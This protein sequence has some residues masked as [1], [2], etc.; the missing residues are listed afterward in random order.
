M[1]TLK[2]LPP[3]IRSAHLRE[4]LPGQSLPRADPVQDRRQLHGLHGVR[5]QLPGGS[6][7]R[8]SAGRARDRS[9]HVHQVRHLHAGVQL[10]RGDGCCT[11][12]H[13]RRA[14][15]LRSHESG[16]EAFACSASEEAV[17]DRDKNGKDV[18]QVV[19]AA[20]AQHGAT[21]D[22]SIPILTDVNHELGYI[23]HEAVA[24]VSRLVGMPQRASQSPSP[25]STTCCR[26]SPR[27]RH[28]I[29]FCDNAPCH[30]VGGRQVW[31]ALRDEL[32]VNPARRRPTIGSRRR[33][34]AASASA[35]WG[36]WW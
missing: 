14:R 26:C 33:P 1:S 3:R 18:M 35:P 15:T 13:R 9:E 30:V 6:H 8:R 21:R 16:R 7:Q 22:E 10:Q 11:S 2:I 32:K 34:R 29:K 12:I 19:R 25:V 4:A 17:D 27:G 5:A 24:E 28:V 36:R 31:Q 20:V 23:P